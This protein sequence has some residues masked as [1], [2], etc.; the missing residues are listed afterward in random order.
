[1]SPDTE[2]VKTQKNLEIF[3][4][5]QYYPSLYYPFIIQI[6]QYLTLNPL[7]KLYFSLLFVFFHYPI[8][9]LSNPIAGQI[10]EALLYIIIEMC[11]GVKAYKIISSCEAFYHTIV[12]NL[13]SL[14]C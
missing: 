8:I 3:Q 13:R 2:I 5:K 11:L 14:T 12:F 1:M 6:V 9:L 7:F 10:T 4:Q